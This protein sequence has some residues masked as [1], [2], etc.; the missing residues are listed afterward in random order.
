MACAAQQSADCMKGLAQAY[1]DDGQIDHCI[2]TLAQVL[3]IQ[4]EDP[5]VY[6]TLAV[7]MMQKGDYGKAYPLLEEGLKYA[8]DSRSASRFYQNMGHILI[9]TQKFDLAKNNFQMGL[10][11]DWSNLDCYFGLAMASIGLQDPWA[12]KGRWRIFCGLIPKIKRPL[13][14][15]RQVERSFLNRPRSKFI[16]RVEAARRLFQSNRKSNPSAL[17]RKRWSSLP[18]FFIGP[19]NFRI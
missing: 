13:E 4:K 8:K 5:D 1:F 14:M 10:S 3:M 16:W 18:L 2:A 11:R 19:E 12:R 7:A 6:G 17:N 15:L 9:Q